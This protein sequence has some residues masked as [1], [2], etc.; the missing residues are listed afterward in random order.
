VAQAEIKRGSLPS[1][2]AL[3]FD[4][5][6]VPANKPAGGRAWYDVFSVAEQRF[7]VSIGNINANGG[8]PAALAHAVRECFHSRA[9]SDGPQALGRAAAIVREATALVGI[10]DCAEHTFAYTS[11]GRPPPVVRYHDGTVTIL[12]SDVA[13]TPGSPRA[14]P[15]AQVIVDLRGASL[16][17]LYSSELVRTPGDR[18]DGLRR[19][20]NVLADDR[21]L[22]CSSPAAWV[23]R[24]MLGGRAHGDVALL[25]LSLPYARRRASAEAAPAGTPPRW[26]VSWSFEASAGSSH[27]ARRAFMTCLASKTS[28][29]PIDLAAAELIFGELL[30]NVVRHAPG[31]V[32]IILDWTGEL[33]VLH[34]LDTGPGFRS[35]RKRERLPVDE[36]SE[37]GRGLFII[38]A[39]AVDFSVRAREDRG[40]HAR[41]TLAPA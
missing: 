4:A 15:P 30:G 3:A 31:R 19:L 6:H 26:A 14:H 16:V 7:G 11:V 36:L 21:I 17:V 37:S 23:A 10:L 29:K 18:D 40:T 32:E 38:N 35:R 41:A 20:Q 34:V 28:A 13:A 39:C 25:V 22:H 2:D 1:S 9:V 24:R 27:D 12:P 33:P 8:D 5:L